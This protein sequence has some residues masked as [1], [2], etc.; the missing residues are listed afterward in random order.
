MIEAQNIREVK[1]L[2]PISVAGGGT[3]TTTEVDTLGYQY[4]L[5]RVHSGLVGANGVTTLQITMGNTSGSLSNLSGG[6][7]TALV[8]ANDGIFLHAYIDLRGK[9]RYLNMVL[10][11]GAT[12]PSLL[13]ASCILFR[14]E[15]TPNTATARGVLEQ[16]IL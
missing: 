5:V 2:D 14:A 8:D 10:T 6:A 11:N 9:G 7:F 1:I 15:S 3:A 12:N 13:E 16:L 4:A